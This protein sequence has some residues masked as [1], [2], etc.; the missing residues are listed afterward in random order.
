MAAAFT[1]IG[2]SS[3]I[4]DVVARLRGL[5]P[6]EFV[7]ILKHIKRLTI[8]AEPII[9]LKCPS[10]GEVTQFSGY[11]FRPEFFLPVDE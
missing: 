6:V 7:E 10:C 3:D 4:M 8:P 2:E 1:A 5:K 11:I 9:N